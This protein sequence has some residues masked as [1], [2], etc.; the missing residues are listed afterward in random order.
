MR[1]LPPGAVLGVRCIRYGVARGSTAGIQPWAG[2]IESKLIRAE[3]CLHACRRLKKEGFEPDVIVA[4][5]GWGESLFVKD[6]WPGARLGIY[7][8]FFYRFDDSDIGFDPEFRS[9]EAEP[10][11]R[12]RLRAKNLNNVAHFEISDQGLSPTVWQADSYPASFRDRISVIHDGIDTRALTPL[13]TARLQVTDTSGE[14]VTVTADDE[15]VTFVNRN[16]EPTRGYHV[17]MRAL[18]SLLAQRPKARVLIVGGDGVSYGPKPDPARYGGRSWRDI[19]IDEVRGRIP[20]AD[21]RR[22][23]FLGNLPYPEFISLLRV[24]TVHVYLTYPFV[25][26]WSLLEAMS[27]EG[28]IVASDT[29]PVREVIA[30]DGTGMLVDFFNPEGLA[31]SITSLLGDPERRRRLGAAARR[32]VSER[33]DLASICLPQRIAWVDRLVG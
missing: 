21:W 2:D 17:F 26:S 24:S 27:L 20:D 1:D 28:A 10:L 9:V 33:Y 32:L 3:A 13:R 5:P 18:P 12:A 19:F 4:H 11:V 16:L 8:E 7:G 6:V 25:L 14:R 22:V 23:L 31:S 29:S 30:H 15:V